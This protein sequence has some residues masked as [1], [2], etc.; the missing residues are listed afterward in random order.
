MNSFPKFSVERAQ[1]LIHDGEL[2]HSSEKIVAAWT[3]LA[4][5]EDNPVVRVRDLL[6]C[7]DYGG[8]IA[9]VGA[10]ALYVRTGRDGFG[11][12]TGIDAPTGPFIVDRSDWENYLLAH[13]PEGEAVPDPS[14]EVPGKNWFRDGKPIV[15]V[16]SR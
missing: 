2:S 1:Q 15:D 16:A 11:W 3:L 7:L 14:R 5:C 6:R 8:T 13:F 10:R 12:M 9:T 4:E